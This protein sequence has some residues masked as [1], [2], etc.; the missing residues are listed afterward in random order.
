MNAN[1]LHNV[2]LR[3]GSVVEV[4]IGREPPHP[5]PISGDKEGR[6]LLYL[7]NASIAVGG[8]QCE[9]YLKHNM[10]GTRAT[11]V[12]TYHKKGS[13][14]I[15]HPLCDDCAAELYEYYCG[16]HDVQDAPCGNTGQTMAVSREEGKKA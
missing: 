8:V 13:P 5:T 9:K 14:R 4:E 7:V 16:L 1:R 6:S 12:V 2:R 3:N 15:A 10:D 11:R